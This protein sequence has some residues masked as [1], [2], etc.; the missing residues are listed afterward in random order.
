M[1]KTFAKA[2]ELAGTMREYI[3]TRIESAKLTAAEKSSAL[4]GNTAAAII[5]AVVFSFFMIFAGIALSLVL[6]EWIGKIWAGY[7]IVAGVYLVIS[8]VAWF[9]RERLIRI[10]VV[11]AIIRQLFKDDEKD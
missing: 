9:G 4:I 2:E 11:N 6:G 1:E 8:L 10:P 5:A 3:N 7:L